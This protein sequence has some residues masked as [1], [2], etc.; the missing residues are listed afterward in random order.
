MRDND[1]RA[2]PLRIWV[3]EEEQTFLKEL[4][5]G[6]KD[7][8]SMLQDEADAVG[9]DVKDIRHYWYKSKK[10]SINVRGGA[11]AK[12]YNDLRDEII[13]AMDEHSP[14]YPAIKR[15]KQKEGHLLLLDIADLHIGKL[16]SSFETGETYN[17]QIAVKRALEG[18]HGIL[19]KSNGFNIDKIAFVIGNDVLHVDNPKNQTTAG[20]GQDTS[21]M[22]YDSFG[23]ARQ[24]YVDVIEVLMT[25]ADVSVI[26][27]PSNHD[28]ISGFMLADSIKSWFRKSEN[29]TFDVSISHRKY[30]TYGQNLIGTTHGD[31]GKQ[32]NLP[33]SMAHE[34]KEWSNCKHR[35]IYT[36]HLHHKVSKDYMGVC[37]ETLRSPSGTDSWHHRNQYEH[38]PKAVEGYLHHKEYGQVCRLMHIF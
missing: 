38:A 2:R 8:K 13:K 27:N 21:Q 1:K 9:I 23:M 4:R 16:C 12:T 32:A 3:N 7:Q 29:V 6:E 30:F 22:W 17:H 37:V 24:L 28:Y 34:A 35:Y 33:L 31:G 19:D 15:E 36:H 5:A 10:Y 20:T 26:Y 18:V 14:V 11:D 25:I